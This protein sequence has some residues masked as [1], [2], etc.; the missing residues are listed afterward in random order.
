VLQTIVDSSAPIL[1]STGAV[2][3]PGSIKVGIL[4][5]LL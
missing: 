4:F 2:L 5:S 1:G 3:T